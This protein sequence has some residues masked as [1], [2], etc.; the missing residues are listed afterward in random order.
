MQYVSDLSATEYQTS[1]TNNYQKLKLSYLKHPTMKKLTPDEI[2]M[3]FDKEVGRFSN[4]KTGQSAAI[5]SPLQM[6]LI[7]S[8]A[9]HTNPDAKKVLD[10]GCGAG[11]YT[12]KLLEKIPN[13]ECTLLDLSIPMLDKARERIQTLTLGKINT[14][15]ADIRERNIGIKI[16]DIVIASA[17]L[18]HLRESEEWK[19]VFEKIY[20]S[21]VVGG[22]FWIHDLISHEDHNIQKMNM[23]SWEDYLTKQGGES[24]KNEVFDY[25]ER[26]DTPRSM[27]FQIELLKEVGF[28]KVEILHKNSVFGSFGAIK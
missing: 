1:I 3:R 19:N 27:T 16:F 17:V 25:M 18:H 6:D 4:L 28:S 8:S 24:Y 21:L 5:D 11:N 26:E 23:N 20:D 12:I 9:F 13:L 10:I 14:I 7:A 15:Q 22:S 2:R